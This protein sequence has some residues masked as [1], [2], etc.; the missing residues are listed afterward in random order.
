[1]SAS[2]GLRLPEKK[3]TPN[4]YLQRNRGALLH[5]FIRDWT[6][7]FVQKEAEEVEKTEK[8][9]GI[10]RPPSKKTGVTRKLVAF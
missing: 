7:R 6:V 9:A 4:G 2:C 8:A 3:E 10:T 1:M 5:L